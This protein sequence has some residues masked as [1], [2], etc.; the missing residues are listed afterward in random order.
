MNKNYVKILIAL[1]LTGGSSS[2]SMAQGRVSMSEAGIIVTE[3][4]TDENLTGKWRSESI[5]GDNN[6]LI[7]FFEFNETGNIKLVFDFEY[8]FPVVGKVK[9]SISVPGVY[10]IERGTY[11]SDLSSEEV[12]VEISEMV[13]RK[14]ELDKYNPNL[15][16]EIDDIINNDLQKNVNFIF[17]SIDYHNV[18]YILT[19]SND[20]MEMKLIEN[21]QPRTIKFQRVF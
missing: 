10:N 9:S 20:K 18:E 14:K 17:N 4:A 19:D 8:E 16:E 13:V 15:L 21:E 7:M 1:A 11:Y 12:A 2:L 5:R 6:L 3:N